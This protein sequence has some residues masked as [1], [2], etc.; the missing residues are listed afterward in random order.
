MG[1]FFSALMT[2]LFNQVFL[3]F[4]TVHLLVVHEL[5]ISDIPLRHTSTFPRLMFEIIAY[6]LM[7]EVC[8]Y[9]AHRLLHTKYLYKWIHKKHHEYTAPVSIMAAYAHP[10][11]HIIA[12][13]I[14]IALPVAVLNLSTS[15]S[16]LVISITGIGTLGDHSGK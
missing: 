15:S 11:E 4:Y 12:N 1:K 13:M 10:I 14:P 6:Q 9:Y 3:N 8:F 16:W 5:V 7:Y 2:V